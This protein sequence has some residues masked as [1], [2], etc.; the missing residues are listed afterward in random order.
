MSD[1]LEV[2]FPQNSG[3]KLSLYSVES[4]LTSIGEEPGIGLK[5]DFRIKIQTKGNIQI[6]I[7]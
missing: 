2:I 5:K 3:L 4:F 1:L 6:I 7:E